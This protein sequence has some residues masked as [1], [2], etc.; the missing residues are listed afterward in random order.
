MIAKV[1][2][3]GVCRESPSD[4][5][6]WTEADAAAKVPTIGGC[7]G[8]RTRRGISE[9]WARTLLGTGRAGIAVN[10]QKKCPNCVNFRG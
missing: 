3:T 4:S 9:A 5:R 8:T 1:H 6:I 2:Y 10:I 7:S